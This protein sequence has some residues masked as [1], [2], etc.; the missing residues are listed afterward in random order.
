MLRSVVTKSVK[1]PNVG[2]DFCE[3]L[4]YL[5]A[6]SPQPVAMKPLKPFDI[7]AICLSARSNSTI[8][9]IHKKVLNSDFDEDFFPCNV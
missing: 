9:G 8:S 7:T 6:G 2:P 1:A 4:I 5:E 3:D